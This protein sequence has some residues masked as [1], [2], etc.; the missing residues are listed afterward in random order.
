MQQFLNVIALFLFVISCKNESKPK[1]FPK[2]EAVL[3]D[4]IISSE[5]KEYQSFGDTVLTINGKRYTLTYFS[6]QDIAE[7]NPFNKKYIIENDPTDGVPFAR[8]EVRMNFKLQDDQNKIVFTAQLMR[9]DFTKV[10]SDEEVSDAS[11]VRLNFAGYSV[12]FQSF[13]FEIAFVPERCGGE[14][15]LL[16]LD[17]AG[18]TKLKQHAYFLTN[19]ECVVEM[20]TSGK[21]I[22]A[23][24]QLVFPK[25]ATK[26]LSDS[27]IIGS[28]LINDTV[29]LV[30][31]E[32]INDSINPKV[33]NAFF[34]NATGQ[35]IK[36]FN[37][38]C[39]TNPLGWQ[40]NL[41]YFLPNKEYIF[42]DEL[43]NKIFLFSEKNPVV[44][45]EIS[46][47]TIDIKNMANNANF[48]TFGFPNDNDDVEFFI[49]RNI[50][51]GS[52]FK[53]R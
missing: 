53:S 22:L 12:P 34:F 2:V 33:E 28:R 20:P 10:T 25:K 38:S 16:T 45:K 17:M 14:V 23:G 31:N 36:K 41:H 19:W 42:L 37:Y 8:R 21:F 1:L 3:S 9:K 43:N 29:I 11:Y 32:M 49:Y 35:V 24:N 5:N 44:F 30:V 13:V 52:F 27:L 40:L 47:S 4:T 26:I 51:T 15:A 6:Q 48:E 18:K 46:L 39:Y 50:K 7:Y